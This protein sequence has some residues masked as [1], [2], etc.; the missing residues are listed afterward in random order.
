LR[1]EIGSTRLGIAKGVE[2]DVGGALV[3]FLPQ[4]VGEPGSHRRD[5]Y[6]GM[7]QNGEQN[8]H[9]MAKKSTTGK[10]RAQMARAAKSGV[11]TVSDIAGQAIRA[12]AIAAAG[13]A[14]QRTAQALRGGARSAE[15]AVPAPQPPA[16]RPAAK[17][18]TRA[19]TA[20]R[21]KNGKK[22]KKTAGRPAKKK[23]APRRSR[24]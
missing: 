5:W 10:A 4:S 23:S 11:D 24:R 22:T 21:A 19:K 8:G 16:R 13:V 18:A 17:P 3:N 9:T 6:D 7:G 2:Q 20:K 12:A 1:Q 15:A 14:L